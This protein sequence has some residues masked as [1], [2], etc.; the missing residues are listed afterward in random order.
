MHRLLQEHRLEL[1]RRKRL[2]WAPES[3]GCHLIWKRSTSKQGMSEQ[4]GYRMLEGR[5]WPH[6]RCWCVEKQ[7]TIYLRHWSSGIPSPHSTDFCLIWW[8]LLFQERFWK[9][10]PHKSLWNMRV[11]RQGVMCREKARKRKSEAHAG[12]RQGIWE[13]RR[14]GFPHS[15]ENVWGPLSKMETQGLLQSHIIW[16]PR[17]VAQPKE[18]GKRTTLVCKKESLKYDSCLCYAMM[19]SLLPLWL[20]LLMSWVGAQLT[21]SPPHLLLFNLWSELGGNC[22]PLPGRSSLLNPLWMDI[23]SDTLRIRLSLRKMEKNK[24][25]ILMGCRAVCNQWSCLFL[26]E[27]LGDFLT[28]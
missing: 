2:N 22:R 27:K 5:F 26:W 12:R 20:F 11:R 13:E 19:I 14:W 10:F 16:S 23:P 21:F 4:D 18:S 8:G 25:K 28:S 1:W 3:V 24:G 9:R 7:L 15:E 6:T 17:E